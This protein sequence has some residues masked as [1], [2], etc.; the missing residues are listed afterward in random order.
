MASCRPVL[1][2]PSMSLRLIQALSCTQITRETPLIPVFVFK[3]L[4][5]LSFSVSYK[6]CVCHSYEN[7]RVCTNNSHSGTLNYFD[8]GTIRFF[9]SA[10][11][12]RSAALL[13]SLVTR[14]L[15]PD[16][17]PLFSHPSKLFCTRQKLNSF[18]FM[19]FRTLCEKHP[20]WAYPPCAVHWK[21][22]DPS[23][24]LVEGHTS[25]RDRHHSRLGYTLHRGGA[26]LLLESAKS[27]VLILSALFPIV[28]PLG[29]SPVF[30][31]LTRD[32]P[33]PARRILARKVAVNSFVLLIEW[34]AAAPCGKE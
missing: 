16:S 29:G 24:A 30:L 3:R 20:G 33:S 31:A 2:T 14:H 13:F 19:Q 4:H 7:C 12:V 9:R 8:R 22:G 6:S 18:V 27:I 28:N 23:D 34:I 32:Y 15:P 11:S 10:Q 21:N 26:P 5:T 25:N 1:L 17:S